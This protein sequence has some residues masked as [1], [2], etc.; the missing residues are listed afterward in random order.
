MKEIVMKIK[1]EIKRLGD[2]P[3]I[4]DFTT[5][6]KYYHRNGADYLVYQESEISGMAGS[7]TSLKFKDGIITMKRIG[8]GG[9]DM[10]FEL[11]KRHTSYYRTPYGIFDMEMRASEI[12]NHLVFEEDSVVGLLEIAY[13]LVIKG[14]SES[15]NYLKIEI[16]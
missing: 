5:E 15:K 11:D 9:A 2:E 8:S 12:K 16:L 10:V 4:I 7:K 13:A 3:T 6:G 1:S 14:L